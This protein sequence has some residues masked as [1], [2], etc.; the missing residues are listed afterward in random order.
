[1]GSF[2]V[3]ESREIFTWNRIIAAKFPQGGDDIIDGEIRT[4]KALNHHS[5]IPSFFGV[6]E[7]KTML[8]EFTGVDSDNPT[9][10]LT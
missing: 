10:G 2:G 1:M 8:I 3:V 4:M 6:A 9:S 7:P 5:G